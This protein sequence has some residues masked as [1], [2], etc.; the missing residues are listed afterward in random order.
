MSGGVYDFSRDT[1][2]AVIR[3]DRVEPLKY[4]AYVADWVID[5]LGQA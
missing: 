2:C 1:G 5:E 3:T 4:S